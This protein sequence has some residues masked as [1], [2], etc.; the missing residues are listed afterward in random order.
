MATTEHL[1]AEAVVATP[2]RRRHVARRL[3]GGMV[4][5]LLAA[6]AGWLLV[7]LRPHLDSGSLTGTDE[8]AV[9]EAGSVTGESTGH[10]WWLDTGD[11]SYW[12][13]VRNDG[14]A[15]VTLRGDGLDIAL[16]Q[17]VS[18]ATIVRAYAEF[19]SPTA[20][21]T[22]QPGEEAQVLVHLEVC[23]EYAAG[24]GSSTAIEGVDV[25]ATTWGLTRKVHLDTGGTYGFFSK[26][27]ARLP[28]SADCPAAS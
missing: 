27:V 2:L 18:F 22:L 10:V 4:V 25:E 11:G 15:P 28:R 21:I 12:T 5:V 14:R 20:S 19:G 13:V 23:G 8:A 1:S 9:R 24:P 16:R 7:G 3:V 17:E 26:T 6:L